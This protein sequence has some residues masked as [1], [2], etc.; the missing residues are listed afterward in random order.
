MTDDDGSEQNRCDGLARR[1]NKP[2]MNALGCW[3]LLSSGN[4]AEAVQ[5]IVVLLIIN[6]RRV[7]CLDGMKEKN[8]SLLFFSNI[9]FLGLVA[10]THCSEAI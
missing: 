8:N 6:F 7:H 5:E 9:L 4:F 3:I 1:D 2:W 10:G